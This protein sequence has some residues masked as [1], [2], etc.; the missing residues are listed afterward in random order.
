MRFI[1]VEVD[2]GPADEEGV[3]LRFKRAGGGEAR[4]ITWVEY[5]SDEGLEGR[6]AV[7]RADSLDGADVPGA[8]AFH[9]DDS[10]DGTVWLIVGGRQGLTLRH[11]ETGALCR[12][13]YLVL[14]IRTALG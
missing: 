3:S 9:V 6:W 5:E 13:P 7:S 4:E 12:A 14:S 2:P 11:E 10:S 1:E 8:Q